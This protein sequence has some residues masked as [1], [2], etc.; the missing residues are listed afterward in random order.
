MRSLRTLHAVLNGSLPDL[1]AAWKPLGTL[2]TL[3]TLVSS[4][5]S[6]PSPRAP[7]ASS[8]AENW[9]SGR[10]T[11]VHSAAPTLTCGEIDTRG[12]VPRSAAAR[13]ALRCT[14]RRA[15]FAIS[16]FATSAPRRQRP[17]WIL[18]LLLL[19]LCLAR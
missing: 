1:A 12:P 6:S 17:R 15:C 19:L 9:K 2:G 5:P 11:P 13:C 7:C 3:G 14:T 4:A 18:A 16:A 10:C 8:A